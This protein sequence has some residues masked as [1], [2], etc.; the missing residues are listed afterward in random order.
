MELSMNKI[1]IVLHCLPSELDQINWIIDQL[2]R[3]FA[4]IGESKFILD[5][6]L[7]ISDEDIHGFY[8]LNPTNP[9]GSGDADHQLGY[10]SRMI[11][12]SNDGKNNYIAVLGHSGLEN[13]WLNTT[14]ISGSTNDVVSGIVDIEEIINFTLPIQ[15]NGFSMATFTNATPDDIYYHLYPVCQ[16]SNEIFI[17]SLSVGTFY[18]MPHSPNL[19]LTM[20]R[21][22][23]GIKTIET[24]SGASLSNAF[25]IKPPMWGDLPPWELSAISGS[26][27]AA[28][29][30]PDRGDA[31]LGASGR[32]IWDLS[33]SY[34]DDGD[35]FGSNPLIGQFTGGVVLTEADG[36][37]GDDITEISNVMFN[38]N[39]LDDNNFYSQ[40][41]H[42]T[43]GGQLP[44]IFQPNKDDNTNFAICKFDMNSFSFQQTSPNLYSV[45]MKIREVW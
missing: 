6:T 40:V 20:S 30:I 18:D 28:H 43:N 38:N 35:V 33:F 1:K 31:K 2:K 44:F 19:N 3:S 15:F 39:L 5:F 21:E 10:Q 25:Y 13:I 24:Q 12:V 36:W 14:S 22:Y 45:K 4:Y 26:D 32:R 37:D 9:L 27:E 17:G 8:G 11:P 29:T 42:K 7:N 16:S 23:G 34:L 41:I